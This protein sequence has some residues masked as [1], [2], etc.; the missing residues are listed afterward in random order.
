MSVLNGPVSNFGDNIK[1]R[2]AEYDKVTISVSDDVES[3][4]EDPQEMEELKKKLRICFKEWRRYVW[5][6]E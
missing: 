4:E 2:D 3:E 1:F 5:I 6:I